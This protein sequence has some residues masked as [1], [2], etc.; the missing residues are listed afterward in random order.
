MKVA[1]I[2]AGAVGGFIGGLLHRAGEN[3]TFIARG[4]H[5]QV[6]KTSGLKITSEIDTFTVHAPFHENIEMIE[7]ADLI[8]FT[9][10][11]TETRNIIE[12]IKPYVKRDAVILTL[13]NGVDNEEVLIEHFGIEKVLAGSAYLTSE[14][15]NAGH[16]L[17]QGK[18]SIV[19]GSLI[20]GSKGV[21]EK[22][23]ELFVHSDIHTIL[24][25]NIISAKWEKLLWNVTF[26]PLSAVSEATVRNILE[27]H[28]LKT[29]AE[30]VLNEALEI[31]EKVGIVLPDNIIERIFTKASYARD[32]QTSMLQDKLNG[33]PMEIES[34]CGFF[35]HKGKE[36]Q[37]NVSILQ[38]LYSLL[39]FMDRKEL[40]V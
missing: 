39:S 14:I 5:L 34:L 11:S 37:V 18:H 31:S 15:K 24:S 29:T 23:K 8:L 20:E 32:H 21:A 30:Q 36:L 25:N 27:N 7:E 2:G 10:K 17:Q 13:Q 9:V 38:T 40:R 28:H 16:I 35:V 26:N 6:M 3:V 4:K 12:Q 1:V 33:K 19:L 22:V